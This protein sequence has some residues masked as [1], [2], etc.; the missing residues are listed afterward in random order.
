MSFHTLFNVLY[1]HTYGIQILNKL[2]TIFEGQK[3]EN[4]IEINFSIMI[5]KDMYDSYNSSSFFK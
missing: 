2:E 4:I 1:I 3:Y 5:K